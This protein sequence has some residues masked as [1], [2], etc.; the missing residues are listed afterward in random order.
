MYGMNSGVGRFLRR[1]VPG[2]GLV[3]SAVGEVRAQRDKNEYYQNIEGGSNFGGF[4][5]RLHEEAYAFTTQGVFSSQEARQAFKGVTRLGFNGRVGSDYSQQGGRQQALNFIYHGKTAYGASVNESL[6][7]LEV[8]SKN[9]TVNLKEFQQALKDISDTAGK[10]GV[11]AQMAR[12]QLTSLMQSA[13]NAGYGAGSVQTASNIQMGQTSLGRSFQNIDLSG[14]MS[15]RYTYMAA[16]NAGMTYNQYVAMQSTNPLA[17]S[18]ARAG[19]NLQILSQIFSGDEVNWVKQQAQAMGGKLDPNSAISIVPA[20]ERQFPN[21]NVSVITQQLQQFGIVSSSDPTEALAY[22]FNLI[23]G[24]NGD[25]ANAQKTQSN[26]KPMSASAADKAAK[27]GS[28]SLLMKNFSVTPTPNRINSKAAFDSPSVQQGTSDAGAMTAYKNTVS[29]T[30]QR[31]PVIEGLL[32]KVK[33]PDKEKVVVHTASGERVVSLADAITNHSAELS[34]GSVQFVSGDNKN[35]SVADIVG[36]N[37]INAGSNWATEAS[38]SKDKSGQTL[39]AWQKA[40][41]SSTPYGNGTGTGANGR[42]IVDLS[43]GAKQLLKIA[44]T[45]GIAGANG[46]GA[47]PIN[48]YPY[49]ANR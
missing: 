42:V 46:E 4:G 45:S 47:P 16:S 39:S 37:N 31:N 34:G 21:H 33:D 24:N 48:S 1:V 41:P 32:Q 36:Q 2:L 7:E 3:D 18:Q 25:L 6:Q 38:K 40:N 20:F 28:N 29:K 26:T 30:N 13:M 17:A 5:E 11:N 35:R 14:Q 49:N 15:Q 12:S 22:A 19:Q 9:S 23:A 44:S 27:N 8:A 43:D 10:A